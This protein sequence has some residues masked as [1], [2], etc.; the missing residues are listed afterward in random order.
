MNLFYILSFIIILVYA[1]E[2][3]KISKYLQEI[4]EKK[5]LINK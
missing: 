5:Y 3:M 4:I 2:N 1:K